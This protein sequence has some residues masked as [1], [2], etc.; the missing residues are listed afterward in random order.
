[1][2]SCIQRIVHVGDTA[3]EIQF[4]FAGNAAGLNGKR[5]STREFPFYPDVG[6]VNDQSSVR[7]EGPQ[8]DDC[9]LGD[10]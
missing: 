4:S 9:I 7:H 8:E 6:G 1:M 10:R 2:R 5:Q 3:I